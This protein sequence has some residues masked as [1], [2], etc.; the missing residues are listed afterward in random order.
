MSKSSLSA[1]CRSDSLSEAGLHKIIERYGLTPSN[2]N[3]NPNI[4]D[5]EFILWACNNERVTEGIIQYLLQYFPAAA[6]ATGSNGRSPLHVAC[7]NKNVTLNIVQLLIDAAPNSVLNVDYQG[8]MPLHSLC[9]NKKLDESAAMEIVKLLIDK[10]PEAVRH[11]DNNG[12]LPIHVACWWGSR[13]LE[14]CRVLI[15]AYPGSERIA[16]LASRDGSLPL[17]YVCTNNTAATVEYLYKLY[18][19]AINHANT[20]GLYPIHF[21]IDG[22]LK[23]SNP[24]VAVNI[25]QFLLDCDPNVKLQKV[26]G[27]MSLLY[28]ACMLE[29]NDSN[30]R[31]ALGVITEIYDVHPEAIEDNEITSDLLD[32]HQQVQSFINSQL[33]YSRQ[34]KDHLLVTTPDDQGQL[35]LHTALQN[36]ARLGSIKLLVKGNPHSVQSP[37]NNGALPLHLACQHYE[38]DSVIMY[39]I[40][41]DATTLRAVDFDNNTALHLACHGAKYE[42]ITLLLEKYDAVSVSKRN[43]HKKLPIDL[44]WESNGVEDRESVEYTESVFRLVRAYPE[45]VMNIDLNVKQ[46]QSTDSKDCTSHGGKKRKFGNV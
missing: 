6:S 24:M 18:P 11:V 20:D 44:L 28:W 23:R 1:H 32:Y 31:A 16:S 42:L 27:T 14:F 43:A 12:Y 21:A 46:Q 13:S 7:G 4:A 39:L 15:E 9:A 22:I 26:R 19:G 35:P 36:N 30:I 38:S 40:G 45:T 33:V 37:D 10:H 29:Y 8:W 17:H 34:A 41:L 2:N 3:N 25:V 5:Y